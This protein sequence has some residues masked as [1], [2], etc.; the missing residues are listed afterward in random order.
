[1]P[2]LGE[3]FEAPFNAVPG[4]PHVNAPG[5][6]GRPGLFQP[7]ESGN[8]L[9][10][11]SGAQFDRKAKLTQKEIAELWILEGGD[12]SKADLMSAIAMA[13][14]SGIVHN[15][16]GCCKGLYALNTEVGNSTN[17]CAF[18]PSCATKFTI[19]FSNNGTE[20]K[21]W[22]TFTNGA[23]KKFLGKSGIHG[24]TTTTTANNLANSVGGIGSIVGYIARIFEPSFWLRVGKGILGFL[25]LLFGALTLMKVLT[26]VDV[27]TGPLTGL[28]RNQTASAA[29]M[30]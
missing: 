23:Y 17:A 9:T 4:I 6:E 5:F 19:S 2:S 16:N 14:S 11:S 12:N 8:L 25:L 30:A 24:S 28:L 27:P 26:G 22:E 20:L 29:G 3:I 21:P 15:G 7:Q 1:V 13:E 10:H 18:K